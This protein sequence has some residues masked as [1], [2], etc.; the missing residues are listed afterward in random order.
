MKY[1]IYGIPGGRRQP[2]SLLEVRDVTVRFGGVVALDHVSFDVASGEICGLIG[3]NGAGKTTLFN[4]LSRLYANHSGEI[5]FAGQALGALPQHRMAGLGIGRTFQNLALFRTLTVRQNIA[6]GTT[7]RRGTGWLA[8]AL[9]LPAVAR[10]ELAQA[11]RVDELVE[12]LHLG[13][14]A[15]L[16]AGELPFGTQKRVELARALASSPRLLLLDEPACG[17]NHQEVDEL[18][19]L[20][21]TLRRRF[22]LTVLLVEHHMGLVMALSDNIVALNFGRKLAEGPP[23][24]VRRDPEL[25]KAYLGEPREARVMQ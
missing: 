19:V 15:D 1:G 6:V 14:V 2:K 16:P 13:K 17:L 18:A 25:L 21:R 5:R 20:I 4:C 22:E 12:L 24:E 10:E 8:H 7:C 9:R 3:P 11:A 23:A